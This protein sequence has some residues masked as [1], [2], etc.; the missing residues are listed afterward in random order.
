[1]AQAVAAGA[2]RVSSTLDNG[3][4]AVALAVGYRSVSRFVGAFRERFGETPGVY[5][6]RVHPQVGGARRSG[7]EPGGDGV[8]QLD[9]PVNGDAVR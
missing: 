4:E 7:A 6:D 1:M 8:A 2:Q 3:G 9:G 5:R